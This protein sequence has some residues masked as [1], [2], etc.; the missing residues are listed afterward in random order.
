MGEDVGVRGEDKGT[1]DL[2][3][4]GRTAKQASHSGGVTGDGVF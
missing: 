4:M 2:H 1:D 3:N